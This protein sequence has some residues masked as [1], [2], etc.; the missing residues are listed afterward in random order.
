MGR[1]MFWPDAEFRECWR[2]VNIPHAPDMVRGNAY[3]DPEEVPPLP[4]GCPGYLRL[5]EGEGFLHLVDPVGWEG[6]EFL[7]HVGGLY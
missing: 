7:G 4:D 1:G 5:D 3:Q 2:R 6:E